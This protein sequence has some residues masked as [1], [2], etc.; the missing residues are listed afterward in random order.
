MIWAG[1]AIGVTVAIIL[2][3]LAIV[4]ITTIGA[5][6]IAREAQQQVHEIRRHLM[7]RDLIEMLDDYDLLD[8]DEAYD[9][10]TDETGDQQ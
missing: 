7:D 4:I 6:A 8:G 5:A 9:W 2:I 1:I 3:L 10:N